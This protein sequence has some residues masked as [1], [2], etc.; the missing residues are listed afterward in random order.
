MFSR[1]ILLKTSFIESF[2]GEFQVITLNLV[3]FLT[4]CF[5]KIKDFQ[6]EYDNKLL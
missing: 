1:L 2:S 5:C 4:S 6:T 3:N